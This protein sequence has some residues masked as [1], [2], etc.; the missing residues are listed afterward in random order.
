[1]QDI[2]ERL[3]EA[4]TE[5]MERRRRRCDGEGT[6][7]GTGDAATRRRLLAGGRRSSPSGGRG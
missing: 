5:T 3:L 2:G 1:M 7:G 6:H 4:A